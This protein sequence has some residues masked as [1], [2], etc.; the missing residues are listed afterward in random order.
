M[1]DT[2]AH[3]NIAPLIEDIDDVLLRA[4]QCGIK[5]I[6][7]IGINKA[8][9]QLAIQ[10]AETYPEV[11]ASVGIHPSEVDE[12]VT[13]LEYLSHPKVVAIGEIGIDLYWRQDNLAL[14]KERFIE[15]LKIA[16]RNDLP[17]IIHS[18]NSSDVIIDILK[19]YPVK[20]VMHCYSE[21]PGLLKD[22][23]SL[24]FYI[25]VGGIVTFKNA[26]D[27]LTIVDNTPLDR[28]LLETDAPY[29]APVPYRG[30]TNE[31]KNTL[32]VLEKVAELRQLSKQTLNDITTEN[33]YRLFPKLNNLI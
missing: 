19:Q 9:N 22:Y 20:G 28:L 25:G 29:L 6:I 17:V 26:K 10:L 2:H 4:K 1:I 3:I 15:Q 13:Y 14:Q 23:L 12:A 11:Y 16:Q 32:F 5:K 18:R 21:H 8:T 24:G 31:P 7:C 33:A 30:K 27:V